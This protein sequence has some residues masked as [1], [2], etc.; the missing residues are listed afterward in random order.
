MSTARWID[1]IVGIIFVVIGIWGLV[2]VASGSV[3]GLMPVNTLL[4]IVALVAGGVLLYGA[5]SVDAARPT[6]GVVGII[7]AVIAILGLF[8]RDLF[9][10]APLN[11]WSLALFVVAAIALIYDWLGTPGE[12]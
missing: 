6:A 5:S 1:L 8:S 12:A 4:A 7:L 2:P 10:L 9:G 3:L 11:G